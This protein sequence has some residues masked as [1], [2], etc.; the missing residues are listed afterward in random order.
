MAAFMILWQELSSC[1][2]PGKLKILTIWPFSVFAHSSCLPLLYTIPGSK[3]RLSDSR[4]T[5]HNSDLSKYWVSLKP[6]GALENFH[7]SIILTFFNLNFYDI[8]FQH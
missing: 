8:Y 1:V 7:I 6:A 2:W 5:A 3:P 4:D